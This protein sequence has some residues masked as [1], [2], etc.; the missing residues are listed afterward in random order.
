MNAET[1]AQL[2]RSREFLLQK[3]EYHV[4]AFGADRTDLRLA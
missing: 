1:P 4:M 2:A 3:P